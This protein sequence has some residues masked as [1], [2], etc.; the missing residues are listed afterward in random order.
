MSKRLMMVIVDVNKGSGPLAMPLL[1]Q[2]DHKVEWL[3]GNSRHDFEN[4]NLSK[5][6]GVVWV[7]PGDASL[8]RELFPQLTSCKW[9]HSW[10]VGLEP[11]HQFMKDQATNNNIS[12]TNAKGAFSQSLAEYAMAAV[13]HFNKHIPLIQT[14]TK[15]KVWDKFVMPMTRGKTMGLVGFGDI[16]KTAAK[17]A[18]FSFGMKIVALRRNK[19]KK[20][21]DIADIVYSSDNESDKLKLFAE[22][23]YILC[24]LPGTDKTKNFCSKK[25]F[26][27]M[28]PSGVF[29]SMGRGTVVDEEALY[30]VLKNKK[31]Q[32]AALD[33]FNVEPLPQESPLWGLD[34]ILITAHNADWTEDNC[35]SSY[36]VFCSN[37]ENF[38]NKKPFETVVDKNAGY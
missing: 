31:I 38:E 36:H 21:N 15:N 28:K 11:L 20:D 14:N 16:A 8:V 2:L 4:K 12:I 13:L 9:V 22:C 18:K 27:A 25:E 19:D 33:V 6:E 7:P 37:F 34:N 5:V 30:N 3:V 17:M 35:E 24:T 1:H 26:E 32:G 29:I 23:D 10:F